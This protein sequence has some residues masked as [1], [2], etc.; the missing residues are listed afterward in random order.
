MSDPDARYGL[1]LPDHRQYR[2]LVERLPALAKERLRLTV[3]FV[4]RE[5]A[6]FEITSVS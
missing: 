1:A 5:A 6:E 4:G 3:Y 2:G